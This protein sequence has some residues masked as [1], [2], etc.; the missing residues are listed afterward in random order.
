V[1]KPGYAADAF[2]Q[3]FIAAVEEASRYHAGQLRKG[4]QIPYVAHLLSVAALVLE[5]GGSED[6]AIAALLRDAAEDAGGKPTL[7][8]IRERFGDQVAMIVAACSDTDVIP[9]PPWRERKETYLAHLAH[10]KTPASVLRV[11]AADKLH[12]TRAILGDYRRI[13]D[14]LWSRFNTKSGDDQL[15]Y[16][17]SLATIF[18]SRSPGALSKELDQVVT[19]LEWLVATGFDGAALRM[20]LVWKQASESHWHSVGRTGAE[21]TISKQADGSYGCTVAQWNHPDWYTDS[22]RDAQQLCDALDHRH[23]FLPEQGTVESVPTTH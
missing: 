9:K 2:G 3:R 5:D 13:G 19:E 21:W 15:W 11:S 4:T 8:A 18:L 7:D 16:Y 22:L 20:P 6:E 23:P 14:D 10:E 17:R 12:N 1:I